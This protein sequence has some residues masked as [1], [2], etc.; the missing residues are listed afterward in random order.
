MKV[1]ILSLY[2]EP[3]LSAGSFRTT[4]LVNALH[5]ILPPDAQVDVITTLPNRYHTF[6]VEAPARETRGQV[7]I[8][9]VALPPHQSGMVDQS[10][11]FHAFARA[12]AAD[13]A[14]RRF[15]VVYATSSRLMTAVLGAWIAKRTR[16]KLFLDIRDIFADTI[17]DVFS[18]PVSVAVGGFAS[19]LERF[20]I[21]SAARVNLVSPG[22]L[23]YFSK[24]YPGQSFTCLTNGVDDEFIN[25]GA[26][27]R[28]PSPRTGGPGTITVVY[29]GNI[30]EG[31]GLHLI[32]PQ[33]GRILGDGVRFRVIG[34]GGRKAALAKAVE[35]TGLSNIVLLNPMDRESLLR[36]YLDADVL[37]LHLNRFDA[38]QKVLP[39]K[40]F[41]Y[42]ALG[43]PILAG[44][45]G[46][47]AA[48]LDDEVPNCAIFAPCDAVAGAEALRRLQLED[49]PRIAFI[50][51]FARTGIS[52]QLARDIVVL[53]EQ[54][55]EERV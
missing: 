24:R 13:T 38:F 23:P 14:G 5:A 30:G 21:R 54:K 1:L 50:D 7:T 28:R 18:G 41:E 27:Q 3:D 11:A 37:F 31:Q 42:A 55:R 45:S 52:A 40:I 44:V 15:D 2:F 25:V 53:G 48:F 9:R 6:S 32:L 46:F 10:K 17:T 39:S 49:A 12:V 22:F 8:H 16:A 51:K 4:A 36:E 43:K 26:Q 47:A 33:L 34:G 20:A 19:I 35:A 29:A